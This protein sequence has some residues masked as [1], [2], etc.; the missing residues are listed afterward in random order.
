[1]Q[2]ICV[3]F[4]DMPMNYSY[5][6]NT[7][8]T[9]DNNNNTKLIIIAEITVFNVAGYIMKEMHRLHVIMQLKQ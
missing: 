4:A 1:M 2:N 6:N 3:N 9:D 8:H 7:N 5:S